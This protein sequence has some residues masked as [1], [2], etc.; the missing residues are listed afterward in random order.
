MRT[1]VGSTTS[2]HSRL[3]SYLPGQ[4]PPHLSSWKML[5]GSHFP[6]MTRPWSPRPTA[7]WRYDASQ[8]IEEVP[9]MPCSR[10][11]SKKRACHRH[12]S[13]THL[14]GIRA[15]T[16]TQRQQPCMLATPLHALDFNNRHMEATGEHRRS[17]PPQQHLVG[18]SPNAASLLTAKDASIGEQA[19]GVSRACRKLMKA[20]IRG[21]RP[22]CS[23]QPAHDWGSRPQR[24]KW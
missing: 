12:S 2:P 22:W 19:R 21:S 5:R 1:T 10:Q 11:P 17:F 23:W 15:P 18:L 16:S 24:R 14:R 8:S 7:T 6:T 4:P 3:L 20:R 9:W 13:V